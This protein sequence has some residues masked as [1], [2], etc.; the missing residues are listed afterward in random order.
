MVLGQ[1]TPSV[2]K[3][4]EIDNNILVRFIAWAETDQLNQ[5]DTLLLPKEVQQYASLMKFSEQEWQMACSDYSAEKLKYLIQFFTMAER[6]PGWSAQQNSPVI[7]LNR[8]LNKKG[9]SL[10]SQE[11]LWIKEHSENQFIPNG[12]L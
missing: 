6:L 2:K 3:A 8:L 5:L 1:W 7:W 11:L 12:S 9:E 10:S 4:V